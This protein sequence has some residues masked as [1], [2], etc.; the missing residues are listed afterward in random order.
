M[1]LYWLRRRIALPAIRKICA[2]LLLPGKSDLLGSQSTPLGILMK[3]ER[4]KSVQSA[5]LA[6]SFLSL[7]TVAG[8]YTNASRYA[9]A[10]PV[11]PAWQE[12]SQLQTRLEAVEQ[13]LTTLTQSI[14]RKS[15]QTRKAGATSLD[16]T[17]LREDLRQVVRE[18]LG[19]TLSY[20]SDA[21]CPAV[22]T[23]Q[24]K[25]NTPEN[26]AAYIDAQQ[27]V[28]FAVL[29]GLWTDEDVQAL[30]QTF[31]HLTTAQQDEILRELIP[32]I[33]RGDLSVEVTEMPF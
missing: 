12:S 20:L 27:L 22:Q 3:G 25:M 18:E 1:Y 2:R 8:F 21:S 26:Q 9:A 23:T 33:N 7:G 31:A 16:S 13:A 6:L 4:V 5:V 19:M 10:A 17:A 30:R 28:Q 14:Q 24:E 29:D 15:H 32:A 11:A